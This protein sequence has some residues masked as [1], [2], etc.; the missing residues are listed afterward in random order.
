MAGSVG[1]LGK[2]PVLNEDRL[3]RVAEI[4]L[5]VNP[6][7]TLFFTLPKDFLSMGALCFAIIAGKVE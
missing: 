4:T 3:L 2:R 6:A 1:L 5:C 7:A